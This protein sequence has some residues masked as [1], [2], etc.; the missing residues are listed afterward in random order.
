MYGRQPANEIP[1]EA[2]DIPGGRPAGVSRGSEVVY[3]W[4]TRLRIAR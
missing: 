1:L 4:P 3:Q 2:G